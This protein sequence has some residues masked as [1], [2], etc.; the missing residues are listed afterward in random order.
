MDVLSRG[1]LLPKVVE[2]YSRPT[3]I[4]RGK[5]VDVDTQVLS[6][7]KVGKL[8]PKIAEVFIENHLNLA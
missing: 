1:D 7:H 5:D 3:R 2:A 4:V 6:H 8:S